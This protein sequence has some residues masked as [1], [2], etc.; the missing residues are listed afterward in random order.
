MMR[1]FDGVRLGYLRNSAADRPYP[2]IGLQAMADESQGKDELPGA[3][4]RALRAATRSDHVELERFIAR[5]NL[6][7]RKEYAFFLNLHCCALQ[8]LRGDW[9]DQDQGDFASLLRCLLDDMQVLGLPRLKL[10]PAPRAPLVFGNRLGVAYVI[11]SCRLTA[12]LQRSRVA[13]EFPT[14]Y[15]DFMPVLP[16]ASFL[17]ELELGTEHPRGIENDEVL[18]GARIAFELL[19][20]ILRQ[21]RI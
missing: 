18:R 14:S 9:R 2:D 3:L 12:K 15:L 21:A 17:Q 19:V 10:Q 11:R 20:G 5:L 6:K 4:Y 16:W 1:R 8:N 13:R 7:A